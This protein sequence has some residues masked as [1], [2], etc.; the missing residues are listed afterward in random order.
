MP[1]R[2]GRYRENFPLEQASIFAENSSEK[3]QT[4]ETTKS[5]GEQGLRNKL[6]ERIG[7]L[8]RFV[9]YTC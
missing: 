2:E 9:Y 3:Y 6:A 4:K 7:L 8:K 5:G 1:V